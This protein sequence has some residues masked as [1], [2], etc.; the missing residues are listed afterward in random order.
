MKKNQ[1]I[2]LVKRNLGGGDSPS[3]LR[4]R[5]HER[6]IE[7]YLTLAFNSFLNRNATQK[8]ELASELGRDAWKFDALTK[9]YTL[10]ILKDA[11]R[12]RYYS[13]L[14]IH[15]LSISNNDGIRMVFP[16]Q[17]EKSAFIPRRQ[18]DTFLMDGLDVNQL[19]G[20][21]Y[22][23]L[24]GNKLWYSGDI[25][26]CWTS[27]MAKLVLEFNEFDDEDDINIPDGNDMQI[28][29]MAIQML[30]QKAPADIIDDSVAQQTTR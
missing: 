27:V 11:T 4:G 28:V 10:D 14:P 3:E 30:Q 19:S 22:Y 15:V 8:A 6:E 29:Q 16:T 2:E 20:M 7:L 26:S 9:V 24:E 17:E 18:L 23:S 12:N 13:E 5:Y 1:L 21:I 25:D